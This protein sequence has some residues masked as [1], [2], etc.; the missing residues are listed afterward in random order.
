LGGAGG[1]GADPPPKVAVVF[2]DRHAEGL[3]LDATVREN[4][5]LGELSRFATAGVVRNGLVETEARARQ[6]R[7][8]VYPPDLDLP[9][10]ALSGGNQQ[11]I[12]VGRALARIDQ[13]C[14]A[15]VLAHPT[16][17][18]DLGAAR[19]I[20]E[21]ILDAATRRRVAVLVI[22]SD[23]AELRVLCHRL[24]VMA[25]GRIVAELPP[26]ATDAE[27]GEKMLAVAPVVPGAP[28]AP[29][30]SGAISSGPHSVPQPTP[31]GRYL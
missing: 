21:Q 25:K 26:T 4:F 29:H 3:V 9:A 1:G 5:V 10:R 31:S 20:H 13:G 24:I 30:S 16:R 6:D 12:V 17:G 8:R 7:A 27:I 11:K 23:L 19:S 14:A 22:S 18:V 15:L 28:G 2:E